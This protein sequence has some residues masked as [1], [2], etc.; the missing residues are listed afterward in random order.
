[1]RTVKDKTNVWGS[2][3][4]FGGASPLCLFVF[5]NP[6]RRVRDVTRDDSR[7]GVEEQTSRIVKKSRETVCGDPRRFRL[8]ASR[9]PYETENAHFA[10]IALRFVRNVCFVEEAGHF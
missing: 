10:P 8:V 4:V 7:G 5:P 3:S 9:L 6:A 1:M 2:V